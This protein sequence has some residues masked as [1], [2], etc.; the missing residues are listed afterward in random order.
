MVNSGAHHV[1]VRKRIH[2]KYEEYPHPNP[3][4]RFLDKLIY[5]V[6]ISG[7]IMTIPQVYNIWILKHTIGVSIITWSWLAI[8][9]ITWTIY[10]IAHKE[11]PI[12]VV[13]LAWLFVE[14]LIIIGLIIY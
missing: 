7:P 9:A 4:K 6:G 8:V 11:M 10:G 3:H 5:F 12:I 13:N 14:I 2:E 1:H